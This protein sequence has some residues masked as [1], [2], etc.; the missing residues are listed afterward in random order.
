LAVRKRSRWWARIFGE[1]RTYRWE[2][3][4][5][6]ITEQFEPGDVIIVKA[7]VATEGEDTSVVIEYYK[8]DRAA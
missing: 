3:H 6:P 2:E 7:F 4:H 5:I 1:V 8:P